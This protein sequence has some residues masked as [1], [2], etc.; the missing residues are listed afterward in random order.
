MH[1]L[2]RLRLCLYAPAASLLASLSLDE[3]TVESLMFQRN[4]YKEAEVGIMPDNTNPDT[5]IELIRSVSVSAAVTAMINVARCVP[6]GIHVFT[7]W[8]C[9]KAWRRRFGS[10]EEHGRVACGVQIFQ[11][12]R[13]IELC[14]KSHPLLCPAP[15]VKAA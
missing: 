13:V 1:A 4:V 15:L 12:A 6:L 2:L 8:V 11:R 14:F 9:T 7:G 3:E 10:A 5:I